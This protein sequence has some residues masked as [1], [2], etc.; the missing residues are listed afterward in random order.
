[1]K[2]LFIAEKPLVA[3]TIVAALGGD[4]RKN[5]K[6]RYWVVG[7]DVIINF[8][9]HMME[10]FEPHD[11]LESHGKWNLD[12]LPIIN[13]PWKLK[14]KQDGDTPEIIK[15]CEGFLKE[16]PVVVHAGDWDD[17]GQLLV[18]EVLDYFNFKGQVLRVNISNDNIEDA[19]KALLNLEDNSIYRN[20]SN[21][22]LSRSLADQM[23]GINMSRLFTLQAQKQGYNGSPLNV[24]R[25]MTVI[26]WLIVNRD[27]QRLG[28]E[29]IFYYTVKGDFD[30]KGKNISVTYQP[31]DK[32]SLDDR[33]RISSESTANSIKEKVSGNS[34]KVVS[35][36]S[37]IET[38]NAPLPFSLLELQAEAATKFNI[39]S[40]D[41]MQITQ[42]LRDKHGCITYNRSDCRYLDDSHYA[43]AGKIIAGLA[44]ESEF[45]T[46]TKNADLTIKSRAFNSKKTTAHHGIIP[47]KPVALS[48]LTIQERQVYELIVLVYLAQFYPAKETER[49][50]ISLECNGLS[51][52]GSVSNVLTFGWESI[53]KESD[54]SEIENDEIVDCVLEGLEGASGLCSSA[55]LSI[56]RVS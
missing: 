38:N 56:N 44:L 6:G 16:K 27:L 11:Y 26:Q 19:K 25:V 36:V 47:D 35:I 9:G 33:G 52:G 37:K 51:F 4:D 12:D 49:K 40:E 29:K 32:D 34:A 8:F 53:F 42:D 18:D 2:R 5:R 10:L 21:V 17:E 50:T 45:E 55:S 1:M 39:N 48:K 43:D 41:T 54:D 22:A 3:K 7:D 15:L 20:W 46:I 31:S 13:I 14:I 24:G 30:F 23:Y 28:H